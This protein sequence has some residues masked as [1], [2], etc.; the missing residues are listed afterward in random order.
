MSK[1]KKLFLSVHCVLTLLLIA[2]FFLG[3]YSTAL[4]GKQFTEAQAMAAIGL[5][6]VGTMLNFLVV[7]VFE[8]DIREFLGVE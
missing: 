8:C 2:P 7:R 4:F 1:T 3:L 6:S 5:F